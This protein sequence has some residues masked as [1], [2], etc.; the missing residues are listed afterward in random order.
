MLM[1]ARERWH[2]AN[3]DCGCQVVV[4]V[5][6]EIEGQNPRCAC[7]GLMKKKYN[8]P[9][10]TYLDF[11]RADQPA[12]TRTSR[13]S[14]SRSGISPADLSLAHIAKVEIDKER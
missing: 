7:G 13:N 6:G 8:S 3:L 14:I 5:G 2:C 11:L 10:Y 4:E 1:K 12:S 9:V